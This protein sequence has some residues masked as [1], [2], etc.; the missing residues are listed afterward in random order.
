MPRF[1]W[2]PGRPVSLVQRGGELTAMR[3]VAAN[4]ERTATRLRPL[5]LADAL[6]PQFFFG[7]RRPT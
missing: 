4:G 7:R 6:A 5:T 1:F 2:S 3:L